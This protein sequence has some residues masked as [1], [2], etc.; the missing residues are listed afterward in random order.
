MERKETI[1]TI[2]LYHRWFS[3]AIAMKYS[4]GYIGIIEGRNQSYGDAL[5]DWKTPGF[6]FGTA[7]TILEDT[8]KEK[9]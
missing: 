4:A 1:A 6:V 7:S 5:A 3:A 8:L 9:I 2:I